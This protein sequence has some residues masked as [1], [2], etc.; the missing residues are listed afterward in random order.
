M[1]T[2][3]DPSRGGSDMDEDDEYLVVRV[4]LREYEVMVKVVAGAI[5]STK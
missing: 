5:Q 1:D 2:T 3:D 4:L